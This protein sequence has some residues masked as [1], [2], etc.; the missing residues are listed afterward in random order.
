VIDATDTAKSIVVLAEATVT[1]LMAVN[2][3]V[4]MEPEQKF[5]PNVTEMDT[6]KL[7]LKMMRK[8]R[9]MTN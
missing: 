4:A 7:K 3:H 8:R 9:T 5:V 6:L 1:T 2:V